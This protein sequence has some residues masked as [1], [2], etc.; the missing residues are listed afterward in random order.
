MPTHNNTRQG[1]ALP[2]IQES[3]TSSS[4]CS[5]ALLIITARPVIISKYA[6]LLWILVSPSSELTRFTYEL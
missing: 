6:E 4:C 5:N 1:I 3:G 2:R